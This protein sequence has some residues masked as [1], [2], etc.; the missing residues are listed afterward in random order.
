VSNDADEPGFPDEFDHRRKPATTDDPAHPGRKDQTAAAG[1]AGDA[2]E[3][4]ETDDHSAE[5]SR[6]QRENDRLADRIA[7]Q[8]AQQWQVLRADRR[9]EPEPIRTGPSNFSRA[10]VPWGVDL[11]AAWSWRVVIIGVAGFALWKTLTFLAVITI[12]LVVALLIA[13]L[14]SPAVRVAAAAGIPRRLAAFVVVL[15]GL[16]IL[17]LL[18]TFVGQQIAQGSTDLADQVV[19][20]LG[21]IKT[22]LKD[23]PLHASDSQIN[24][25]IDEAQ[26]GIKRLG[27]GNVLDKVTEV[28]TALSH[29]LAGMFIVLFATYF[30]L[31]DGHHI[32]AWVVRLA[33]R[34][35]RERVDSSGRVAWISLTRF[36]RATVIVA[37]TDAMGVMV[38]AAILQV[39]LIAAIG[40]VVFLGAFVPM[41]GA[42]VAGMVAVL[43]ALVA[44]GPLT[45]LFMLIGVVI[46]QQFESHVLQPFLMGRWVSVHPLGV[47]LAIG[48]GVLVA[49]VAGALIAVPLAAAVN[50]VV[51]H[52]AA[53]TR[54]GDDS[55]Q[56]LEGELAHE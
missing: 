17:V 49:G 12:P 37:L 43:V 38:A 47:I 36:V 14:A 25:W 1:G 11:A 29:V 6:R 31:A 48:I 5:R 3:A 23:G 54:I 13:A 41:L 2:D 7:H 21:E 26:K 42:I 15:G 24:N 35:A 32:W 40:V 34:A 22:W 33:P 28:G 9:S 45:A 16:A 53:Y 44:Q 51:Q 19:A 20:G 30:F 55:E 10:Q 46:V 52:L 39:P 56:L 18:F 27:E 50:A 8:F 4:D